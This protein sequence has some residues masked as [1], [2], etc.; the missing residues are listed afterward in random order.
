VVVKFFVSGRALFFGPGKTGP[1]ETTLTLQLVNHSATEKY[2]S[3]INLEVK[4]GQ[5]FS[6]IKMDPPITF[7]INLKHGQ[8]YEVVYTDPNSVK[9]TVLS[10]EKT[11]VRALILDSLGNEYFSEWINVNDIMGPIMK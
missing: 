5:R 7:P 1:W 8:P 10:L 2:I 3:S 6:L 4:G 11:K 9:Q